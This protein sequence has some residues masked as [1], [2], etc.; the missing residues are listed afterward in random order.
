MKDLCRPCLPA[1]VDVVSSPPG[2][3]S[4]LGWLSS[5]Y[6]LPLVT[7]V[8]PSLS[9]LPDNSPTLPMLQKR[10]LAGGGTRPGRCTST[11]SSTASSQQLG[12]SSASVCVGPA[13]PWAAPLGGWGQMPCLATPK[14]SHGRRQPLRV[15]I[16]TINTLLF[17][18]PEVILTCTFP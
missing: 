11:Q 1:G 17:I 16:I 7:G 15:S 4:T 2:A 6:L 18:P 3:V 5:T 12:R 8:S 14:Q 13:R 10:I 9:C